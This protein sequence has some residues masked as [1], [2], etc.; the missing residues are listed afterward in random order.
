LLLLGYRWLAT[1]TPSCGGR[2]ACAPQN[3]CG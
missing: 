1:P 2:G 3:M